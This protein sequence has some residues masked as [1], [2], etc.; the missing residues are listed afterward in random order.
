MC[1]R[2]CVR[3]CVRACACVCVRARVRACMRARVRA[4][5]RARV[6]ACMR[7]CVR[8]CVCVC[9]PTLASQWVF[10]EAVVG[11]LAAVAPLSLHVGLAAALTRDQS[12]AHVRGAVAH[13]AVHGAHRVAVT[14]YGNTQGDRKVESDSYSKA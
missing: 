1:V 7:A 9:V 14:L 11:L 6:R 2:T 10:A 13:P 8:A 3:A 5:V 4:H 12:G